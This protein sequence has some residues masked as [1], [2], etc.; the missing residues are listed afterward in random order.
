VSFLQ[1]F[2]KSIWI[3]D[4]YT[5]AN[6]LLPNLHQAGPFRRRSFCWGVFRRLLG[7]NL[8]LSPVEDFV[9]D[10]ANEGALH[11]GA[12]LADADDLFAGDGEH[13]FKKVSVKKGIEL[14]MK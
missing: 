8:L 7:N 4:P 2:H 10:D 3:D 1:R 14:L 13:E 12:A 6:D 5:A 11:Q 9:R